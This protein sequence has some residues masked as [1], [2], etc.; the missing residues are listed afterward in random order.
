MVFAAW[1]RQRMVILFTLTLF[2]SSL[3]LF[4]V[5]PMVAKMVLPL[6][7]GT[8]AVWNTSVLFF[9]L[10]LLVGYLYAHAVPKW[11]G[12]K[13]QALLHVGL[14]AVS[15]LALPIAARTHGGPPTDTEPVLWLL[16][17]LVVTAG[18]PFFCVSTT[19]PLLQRWFA[20]TGHQSAADPYFLYAAGNAGSLLA[21][22]AYPTLLEPTL[23]LMD[24]SRLWTVGYGLLLLLVS[25]CA[26]VLRQAPHGVVEIVEARSV[27]ADLSRAS[28]GERA[29]WVVL[30]LASSSLMLG[31]TT[32][33]T[34]D[35]APAPLLWVVPLAIYLLTF[36]LVF[37]RRSLV[38]HDTMVRLLPVL[39]LPLA[40]LMVFDTKL[41]APF[42]LAAHL[43]TFFV[44]AMVCHG[45]LARRRPAHHELTR[46]YLWLSIGGALG[47]VFNAVLA[48]LIFSSVAE[49]P[50]A[51]VLACLL[52][53]A[54]ARSDDMSTALAVGL[55]SSKAEARPPSPRQRRR[56]AVALRE[57]ARSLALRLL[58]KRTRP[59]ERWWDAQRQDRWLDIVIPVMFGVL[60]AII[61]FAR[62]GGESKRLVDLGLVFVLPSLI[63]FAF[64]RR[65][66]RFALGLGALMVAS[67]AY[68]NAHEQVV[69]RDRSFFGV[70]RV[71]TDTAASA[72]LLVHGGIVHGG[73]SLDASRRHEPLMYFSRTG[74]IGQVFTVFSGAA[75]KSRVG[76]I[77]LGVGSLAAYGQAGQRWTFFEIDPA[78]EALAK[79]PRYFTFLH[80]SPAAID[81]QIGDARLSLEHVR[82]RE[83]GLLI[84]DAFSSDAIPVHLLTREALQ[85]YVSK[86]D[87]TGLL[88]FHISN[89]YL[90]LQPLLGALAADANLACVAEDDLRVSALDQRTGKAASR[91]VLIA[92]RAEDFG[93]LNADSRWRPLL[94]GHQA[95]WTDDFSNVLGTVRWRR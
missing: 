73:Q 72:R 95:V 80:D 87:A 38:R 23:R 58:V 22:V 55:S 54:C 75:A 10:M 78:V 1:P 20:S 4:L 29:H 31:V 33:L 89:R 51:L 79:N 83:Y 47:G 24:Q 88:A 9:Q 56:A 49:Y 28:V 32:F 59:A 18:V 64:R 60:A 61:M 25:G 50:M 77:G 65:P 35:I 48:P 3:L 84:V 93:A 5:Q 62:H 6:L 11:L 36:I 86:I 21:L 7:G 46:F 34:A 45:E 40:T 66:V 92:R 27:G 19:S 44:A 41:S 82:D 81:V 70:H 2:I 14:L 37:A 63:C 53:P 57:G 67:S 94:A 39:A 17:W 15:L 16:Q 42:Q 69:Y 71:I 43:L 13:R 26:L 68:M 74:P 12:L 30:A 91:W 8:P 52:R 76:V 90:D 85:L